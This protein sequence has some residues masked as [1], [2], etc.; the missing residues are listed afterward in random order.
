[1]KIKIFSL[2]IALIVI[3]SSC[4][5]E[6]SKPIFPIEFIS[7]SITNTQIKIITQDGELKDS[8]IKERLLNEYQ[9]RLIDLDTLDTKDYLK[10]IYLSKDTVNVFD[11][12]KNENELRLIEQK[13]DI[14]YWVS[15]DTITYLL[16]EDLFKDYKI[17]IYEPVYYEEFLLPV[18]SGY[19]KA[20]KV[21]DCLY[22]QDNG[23]HIL[24]PMFDYVLKI[25]GGLKIVVGMNNVYNENIYYEFEETDT[26]IIQEYMIHLKQN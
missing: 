20:A 17:G 11:L 22:V 7:S 8:K 18:S 24:L 10:A 12:K 5:K 6:E 1:M 3:T 4:E 9:E 15:F 2:S 19:S 13:N 21:I 16:F 23:D 14:T 26:L 25:E